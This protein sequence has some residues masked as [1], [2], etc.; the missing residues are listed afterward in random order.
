MAKQATVYC[1]WCRK[2]IR[3]PVAPYDAPGVSHGICEQCLVQQV[4]SDG[5]SA[6]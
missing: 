4:S 2:L 6:K 1:A 3:G 5:G